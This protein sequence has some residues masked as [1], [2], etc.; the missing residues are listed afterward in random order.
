MA[1]QNYQGGPPPAGTSPFKPQPDVQA[2]PGAPPFQPLPP[3]EIGKGRISSPA[4]AGQP[5]APQKGQF[6]PLDINPVNQYGGQQIAGA[7]PRLGDYQSVH[8]YADQAYANAARYLEPA[9][10][11]QSDRLN[12]EIINK[13]VDPN[14]DMGRAMKDDLARRQNDAQNSAAF[15]ALGFGQGIQNQ[16]F[17]QELQKS[18]LAGDMQKALWQSQLGASGQELQK[19]VADQNFELGQSGQALERY[20]I[21][22]NAAIATAANELQKYGIDQQTAVQMAAQ[23]VQQYGMQLDY[24][25]GSS[26]QQLQKYGMDQGYN[27]GLGNL[28]LAQQG[29][30][31]NQM[32]GLEGI[33]FR[34]RQYGD[35]QQQY[36][37]QLMLALLGFDQPGQA[38]MIDPSSA[39][40][41]TIGSAGSD[42]GLAGALLG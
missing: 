40:G 17:G 8:N 16:M 30:D 32:L 5:G 3:A 15:S 24:Q 41:T 22:T 33:D 1:L 25:L 12:Q 21:D 11:Q 29:Q 14:S 42:K 20:G 36:Q 13:G 28:D 35:Q 38:G 4:A 23:Q 34:N 10:E 18:Q 37:D 7:D 19:Y 26:G 9:M 39:F 31:F 2:P 27:L 6:A